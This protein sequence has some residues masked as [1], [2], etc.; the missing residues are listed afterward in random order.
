MKV[1]TRVLFAA[2][3]A[4]GLAAVPSAR[5]ALVLQYNFNNGN[6]LAPTD[7]SGAGHNGTA[8]G[9]SSIALAT[10]PGGSPA[11]NFTEDQTSGGIDTGATTSTLGITASWTG[12]ALVN[13]N[14][15]DAVN[16]TD[17]D[18]IF[19]TNVGGDSTGELHVGFRG[20]NLQFGYW[21]NDTGPD[22]GAATTFPMNRG[23]WHRVTFR[24][25][26]ATGE[27]AAYVD[28]VKRIAATGHAS[29]ARGDVN[30]LIGFAGGNGGAF[31]GLL[32]DVRVYNTALS[33]AE[34]AA[35]P[36]T[37]PV[38]EPG[39]L[40]LAGLAVT[41]LLVARRRRPSR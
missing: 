6:V 29:F 37:D 28:G 38:P 10:S 2:A 27:Q 20:N 23:E 24:Y 34:I 16:N 39:T 31:G 22:Q 14:N 19:G 36:A 3:A 9:P 11:A 18:M 8:R 25:D 26:G 12:T 41:G 33:D 4:V 15:D 32:D 17:D 7:T 35:L 21:G 30:L 13:L 1:H 5:G 40:G